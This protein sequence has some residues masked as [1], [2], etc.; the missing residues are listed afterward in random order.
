MSL[1]KRSVSFVL[2]AAMVVGQFFAAVASAQV[3]DTEAPVLIHRQAESAGVVGDLQTFLARVSDDFEI[4]EVVLYYRQSDA[5]P[6]D[7]IP[8]RELLDTLGEYMIAIETIPSDYSGLQYYIEAVDTSGNRAN[9]GYSYAPIVL[10]L[11]DP[12]I[13]NQ[14][15]ETSPP[16]AVTEQPAKEKSSA[17]GWLLGIGA[18]LLV[19]ALA[20]GG[21]GSSSSGGGSTTDPG[22]VTLTIVTDGPTGN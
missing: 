5:G 3:A 1:L 10:T 17:T 21:G 16:I 15:L 11:E 22:T 20:S 8:M 18:L 2:V 13:E 7:R 12:A 9:R 6:F 19:G 14:S 4:D